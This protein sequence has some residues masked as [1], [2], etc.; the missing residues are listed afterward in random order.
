M[1]YTRRHV[2]RTFSH[3]SWLIVD[4]LHKSLVCPHLDYCA[5]AWRL[6]LLQEFR[7]WS[8]GQRLNSLRWSTL[9]SRR[10]SGDDSGFKLNKIKGFDFVAPNT[11]LNMS[12]TGLRGYTFKL[13]IIFFCTN[14]DKFFFSSRFVEDWNSLPQHVVSGNIVNT[15]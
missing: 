7:G 4:N 13:F 11:F 14:M 6:F 9:E 2:N 10:L 1:V 3:K 8:Y 5:Q 12:I 15:F